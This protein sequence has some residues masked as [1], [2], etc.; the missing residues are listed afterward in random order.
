MFGNMCNLY[1]RACCYV[2]ITQK[3]SSTSLIA[4]TLQRPQ[5]INMAVFASKRLPCANGGH[6]NITIVFCVWFN[7]S[8]E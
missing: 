1:D 2:V 3:K 8:G 5:D 7:K 6:D 4:Y